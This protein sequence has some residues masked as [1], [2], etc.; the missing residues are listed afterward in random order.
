MTRSMHAALEDLR[1][2]RLYV[3]YPGSERYSLHARVE[4]L[5]F[6][7]MTDLEI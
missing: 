4:A 6:A 5:P 3:I 2:E 7:D 1:L